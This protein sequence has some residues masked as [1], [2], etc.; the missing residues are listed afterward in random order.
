[1]P[2]SAALGWHILVCSPQHGFIQ[3]LLPLDSS[4]HED[5]RSFWFVLCFSATCQPC[6]IL[7]SCTL[8]QQLQGDPS[9]ICP[10]RVTCPHTGLHSME[11]GLW[12]V[13]SPCHGPLP[14]SLNLFPG[15]FTPGQELPQC[16][17]VWG[18]PQR[19]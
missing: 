5:L 19:S 10:E 16:T 9:E 1:M 3:A 11:D 12:Q 15:S 2:S 8:E 18:V 13:L 7:T 14:K 4:R 6:Y 17:C